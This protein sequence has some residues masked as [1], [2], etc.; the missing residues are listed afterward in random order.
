MDAPTPFKLPRI[1]R[2]QARAAKARKKAFQSA[3][4]ATARAQKWRYA[5]GWIFRQDD[6][7]FVDALPWVGLE[8]GVS[9]QLI[10]KPM[11]LDTLFWEIVGLKENE[12]LPLSIRA[13]GAW[14]LRPPAI[15]ETIGNGTPDVEELAKL[16]VLWA[17]DQLCRSRS[18]RSVARL[19]ADLPKTEQ[20]RGRMRATAICLHIL[21]NDLDA[22]LALTRLGSH[23]HDRLC[24]GG[25]L[26]CDGEGKTVSFLDQSREWI[27]ARRR[28][29]FRLV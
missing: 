3:L 11:A 7:W 14:V 9:V 8:S 21:A 4:K 20:L 22:A 10:L 24:S 1:S 19:L 25:F 27:F 18:E 23:E 15:E 29:E 26:S 5:G 17:D 6:D 12:R 28:G 13:N 2:E 16:V